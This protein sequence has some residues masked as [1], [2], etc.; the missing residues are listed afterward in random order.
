MKTPGKK[1]G[2][3]KNPLILSI[4]GSLGVSAVQYYSV[5]DSRGVLGGSVLLLFYPWG[6][7]P[8]AFAVCVAMASISAGDRQS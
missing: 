1:P 2:V 6:R 8:A 3:W 5:L 7:T 4:S